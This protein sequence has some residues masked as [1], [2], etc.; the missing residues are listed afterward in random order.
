MKF[1]RAFLGVGVLAALLATTVL[2][3]EKNPAGWS[4]RNLYKSAAAKGPAA[5]VLNINNILLWVDRDGFFPWTHTSLA[6]WAGEYP[7]GTGGL[8]FAEGMLWGARV[9]DAGS[10]DGT[11]VTIRVNGATYATGMKAGKVF[12]DASGNV[13]GADETPTDRHVWR[14]RTDYQ[15]A[16]LTS[17][18]STFYAIALGDIVDEDV[19]SLYAQYDYD[20]KNWPANEG[21]PY[22]DRNGIAGYQAAV[23][24]VS[25]AEPPEPP[26][27]D[28]G[29]FPGEPGASQTVWLVSNDLPFAD[30]SEVA[31][32]LYGSPGTGMEM[33]LTMWAYDFA[34]DNPLGNMLFKR[35]RLIYTGLAAG[36]ADAKLDTVYFTQWSDPDLGVF[37]DDFVG[38]D[39]TL[40][41]GYVYNGN[42]LDGSFFGDFGLPVPAG[43]YDFLQGPIVDGDTLPMT[44]FGWFGAG[45]AISDPDF[46]Y[47]GT[48]Q[49]FNLMEGFL[50]RPE[51]PEQ[52]PWTNI[53]TGE[54]TIFPLAGDP[55]TG[56]GDIDGL[57]LPPG[58]RRLLLNTGPF[59]MALGDTQEV[60]IALVAGMGADNLSSITV[61]KYHDVFAQFAYD[62]D[63]NLPSPP[64]SPKV[65]TFVG[66]G[67][68]TLNWGFD[69]VVV[70]AT[71]ET[72]AKD[73]AF[74]GYNVYQLP[75]A[76]AG[77]ALG[78]RIATFDIKNNVGTIFENFV[79]VNSGQLLLLPAQFGTNQGISRFIHI[80]RDEL[81][82]QPISNDIPYFFGISAYSFLP[83]ATAAGSPFQSLESSLTV[84][85]VTPQMVA[86]GATFGGE[87]GGTVTV[88]QEGTSDGSVTVSIISP[89]QFTG[90]IYQVSF[91]QQHFFLDVDGEYKFTNFPDS[92]GKALGKVTDISASTVTG[93]VLVSTNVGTYDIILTLDF[94]AATGEWA[95]GFKADLPA[96]IEV[97]SSVITGGFGSFEAQG[98]N[99]V[100]F[101][102]GLYDATENSITWG[103]SARSG[104]GC[105]EA[106]VVFT[107]NVSPFTL[108]LTVDYEVYDDGYGT[109]TIDAGGSITVTELGY[110]FKTEQHWN[111]TNTTS[112]VLLLE[113]MGVFDGVDIYTDVFTGTAD[114]TIF[115]GFQINLSGG[116]GAPTDILQWELT[117][118]TGSYN[119]DTFTIFGFPTGWAADNYVYGEFGP[120]GTTDVNI[121][122]R[123]LE[124]RFTGEY[125]T[126]GLSIKDGTGS[127][128]TYIGASLYDMTE[129]PLN[130]DGSTN[131]F[132][133]R[134]PFEIWDTEF[135]N[136]DGTFGR[137]VTL[138]VWDRHGELDADVFYPTWNPLGRMYTW[139]VNKPYTED[140]L[141]PDGADADILTWNIV[142]FESDW[143][144]GD[145][146]HI[147][148]SNPIQIGVDTFT[149]TTEEP[150]PSG[151]AVTEDDIAMINVFPNPYYGF[152]RLEFNRA[153]K[154]VTFNHLPTA[155]KTT[156][157]IFNLGGVMVKVIEKAADDETQYAQ[158]DLKNQSGLPVASGIYI[159]HID[160]PDGVQILKLAIV[161]EDQILDRY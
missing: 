48:L 39:T 51:Y 99:C 41:L 30:G 107:I 28:D 70:A 126:D 160:T 159:A 60:V 16:D 86:A 79:D 104:F 69:P 15:S 128:A 5:T 154:Y 144:T 63:F 61:M 23:W 134:I 31:T 80:D 25:D 2:A 138:I 114:A 153:A 21:A 66:D 45:S 136:G 97:L 9:D 52:I 112:G 143:V 27:F 36:P 98:Q 94:V 93:A 84:V 118:G 100:N 37:T 40:S 42:T 105:I 130:P 47:S 142:F 38:N 132:T 6:S 131:P 121:L 152:H 133:I 50:P 71:E 43:G 74:E 59:T 115:D 11:K 156:I 91:D 155:K 85:S 103:D 110:H 147:T 1:Y 90:D 135:D 75:S 62:N 117:E 119:V 64:T 141:D 73:F 116:Y 96:G 151:R 49:W 89:E 109:A 125:D 137:Q 22:E 129:H 17:D 33:Q 76:T 127:I 77:A 53:I 32:G 7:K 83:D 35:A 18:A 26:A 106:D 65:S 82:S 157:R 146:V 87:A 113:D 34:A 145:V 108:P 92:V 161:Q 14:V 101:P 55:V 139:V 29:D 24:V 95:D 88:V 124:L 54:T 10:R 12:Y 68:I 58:D 13:T 19:D 140:V 102:D 46:N 78:K 111:L 44:S 81:R 122:Q 4:P 148:Y 57:F 123:D 67:S 149:W 120:S 3:K 56:E 150:N 158:W 72:V 8:I 20:W